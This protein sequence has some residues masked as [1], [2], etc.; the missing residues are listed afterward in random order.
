MPFWFN[1]CPKCQG[2]LHREDD[3]GGQYDNCLNCGRQWN[4]SGG[5]KEPNPGKGQY[6]TGHKRTK[7]NTD[8][9]FV[10]T[11]GLCQTVNL[12]LHPRTTGSTT[13]M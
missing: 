5:P 7:R 6:S 8:N 2:T 13:P 9:N 11:E 3:E 10:I 12:G 1:S 4:Y